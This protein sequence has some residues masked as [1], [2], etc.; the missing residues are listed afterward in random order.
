[1]KISKETL[2]VLKNFSAINPNLVIEQ[3]NKLSTIA[4]AKNIMASCEVAETFDKDIGIYDLNEFLSALSLIEDPE[5]VFG[6]QSVSIKSDLTSL[7]YRYA[8]RSILTSPEKGVNM[9]EADVNVQLSA[10]V[11]NHIRRAGAALNHPIVSI[12]TNANDTKLY[13][14][15]K[16]PSNSSSNIFQHEIDANYDAD[17][18][19][20][21]QFLISNLKLIGGDYEV[22]VSSKLISHWKCINNSSVEYWIALEKTS[23]T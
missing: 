15:V 7:T 23:V 10:E 16:D 18:T 22:S 11:I 4:E 2:D 13:L 5:F 3:G 19:F 20:D 17:S 1:M 8:D 6:D 21:F 14:Q 12:T 9:P